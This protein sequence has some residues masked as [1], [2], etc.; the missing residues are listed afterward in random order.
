MKVRKGVKETVVNNFVDPE[1]G[2]ILATEKDV[3][4]HKIFTTNKESFAIM[5]SSVIGMVDGLDRMSVRLIIW[6]SQNCLIN[7]NL[8]NLGKPYREAIRKEF[9]VS[10]QTIK[11]AIYTLKQRRV[12]ISVG[13]GTYKVHPRYFWRGDM[14][15]RNKALKYI[16]EVEL[17]RNANT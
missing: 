5:F 12:L 8:I 15:N 6:C 17:E 3:K 9:Q 4:H 14:G 13:G 7:S 2:E 16:L 10:D 1:T 11:N